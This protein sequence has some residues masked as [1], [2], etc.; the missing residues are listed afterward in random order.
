MKTAFKISMILIVAGFL[1]W[2]F[3]GVDKKAD[4]RVCKG[5]SLIVEDS[6]SLGMI[7]N[8][9][10]Q[11]IMKANR[12]ES[13]GKKIV[14]INMGQIEHTLS[15]SPYID[16]VYCNLNSGGELQM[17]V[18][19]KVPALYVIPAKG[20]PY[21]LDRRGS[22]MPIGNVSANLCVATG[23]ITKPFARSHLASIA[24]CIQDSAFWR[25]QVQ[26]IEVV[27]EH[28][29]RMY[30]R[31]ADHVVLLGAA[32]DLPDQLWR[33]RVFYSKGLSEIGWD[34]YES[35]SVAYKGIVIGRTPKE[36]WEKEESFVF[37]KEQT[38]AIPDSIVNPLT[39]EMMKNPAKDSLR[40]GQTVSPA[41]PNA[42]PAPSQT[43]TTVKI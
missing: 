2:S 38:S 14:E 9:E 41:N 5:V 16:T 35:V 4:D 1:V 19:P 23:N 40:T 8:E 42:K 11:D 12:M 25:A 32:D 37:S 6:L 22:D 43:A 39:G 24:R 29:I 34:K 20:N 10:V 28:D 7:S 3:V 18:I 15:A 33:L 26:Q 36:T 27:N 17:R 21:I 13:K 30:T 31:F